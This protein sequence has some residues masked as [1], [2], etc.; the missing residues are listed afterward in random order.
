MLLGKCQ[1]HSLLDSPENSVDMQ[2]RQE[3]ATTFTHTRS[4]VHNTEI[5]NHKD[6]HAISNSSVSASFRK[7]NLMKTLFF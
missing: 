7:R 4:K 3:E 5:H 6:D 1:T 2:Q